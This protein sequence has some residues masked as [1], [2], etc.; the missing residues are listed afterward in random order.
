MG[1]GALPR[2]PAQPAR[3]AGGREQGPMEA[4]DVIIWL[5]TGLCLLG[6]VR[7]VTAA[8]KGDSAMVLGVYGHPG[9]LWEQGLRLDECGVNAVFVHAGAVDSALLARARAE[10]CRVYAEFATLNGDYG[11]YVQRHPEAHPIDASGAPVARAT[12]FMGACPTD[13]GF[14]N[15]RMEELER[16]LRQHDLDG[17]WMDYL[18]WHAQFED[19]YPQFH[20]TCFNASCVDAFQQWAAVSVPE[21]DAAARAN[22]ILAHA[23]RQWEDWRVAVLVDWAR[24][25]RA[26]VQ[27]LR[28]GALVGNF[29]CAWRD[30]DLW[31][32][33]RRCLGLDLEALRP[34]VDVFSPMPYHGRSGMPV[35]YVEEYVRYLGERL[36]IRT[37]P[38]QYPRLWPIVQAH[39]DPPV[40]ADELAAVLRGGL[41]GRST[42]VMMFTAASVA[43]DPAKLAAMRA[44]YR[45]AAVGGAA[46]RTP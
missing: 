43:Q 26:M 34:Y 3:N 20:K 37:E 11:D 31:G 38:G 2:L 29:H 28:P 7:A 23:P 35:D 25:V 14:R 40:S 33:R 12:W 30:E 21:A 17:V 5:L 13:P 19:A 10:G 16:L 6:S 15:W 4:A 45:Q 39:D 27:R 22:W 24:Q 44:V 42:G 8:G 41:A 32:A 1:P 36:D 46:P 18:H 9:P